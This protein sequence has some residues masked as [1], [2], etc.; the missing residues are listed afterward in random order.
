MPRSQGA[1]APVAADRRGANGARAVAA[2]RPI[3]AD[4]ARNRERLLTVAAAMFTQHGAEVPLEDVARGAGVG[5]G[6]LYRH[7]PTRD[8][9]VEAVYRHEVESL[10]TRADELLEE[11]PPDQA[12][13]EWMQAFVQ[14]VKTKRGMLSALKPLLASD[15]S[16]S[17]LKGRALECASRLLAAGVAA[18]TIRDDIDG[19]DLVRA[20]SGICM[21]TD[22]EGARAA[23]RLVRVIVDGLRTGSTSPN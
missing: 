7:F 20:V 6:T 11:L 14:H 3:R 15:S 19:A 23:E 22:Q 16:L 8:A 12:V 9:L 13:A 18:G 2:E 5:I 10:C 1:S 17:A 21:S 4:A